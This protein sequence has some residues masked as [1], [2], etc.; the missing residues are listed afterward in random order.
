MAICGIALGG[1]IGDTAEIFDAALRRLED[2]PVSVRHTSRL[3]RTAPMGADAGHDFVNAAAIVETSLSPDQLLLTLHEIEETL[4]RTRDAHWGPRSLDMDLLYHEQT[5]ICTADLV[6]PH[7]S[8]WYRRFVLQPLSE[9]A[10]DYQHPILKQ[11]VSALYQHLQQRPLTFAVTGD[12]IS[13]QDVDDV[14]RSLKKNLSNAVDL[15]TEGSD[16][17]SLDVPFAVIAVEESTPKVDTRQPRHEPDRTI[18]LWCEGTNV[19]P[20]LLTALTDICGAVMG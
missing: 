7:P 10:P 15:L 17:N 12:N 4:G 3:L 16:N 6:V 8:F 2:R 1:N 14:G 13:E 20:A 19:R 5:V 9:I 11:N 18:R